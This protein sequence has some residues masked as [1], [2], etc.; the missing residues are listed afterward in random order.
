MTRGQQNRP[1]AHALETE[2]YQSDIGAT[3]FNPAVDSSFLLCRIDD[4]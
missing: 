3:M 1:V 2:R 4:R